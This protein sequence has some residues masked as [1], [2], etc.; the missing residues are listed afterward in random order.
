MASGERR[1]VVVYVTRSKLIDHTR[2]SIR[3]RATRLN[4]T[5]LKGA[6]LVDWPQTLILSLVQFLNARRQT[7]F[8]IISSLED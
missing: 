2:G 8:Q 7:E 6:C 1:P 3:F 4:E 5:L